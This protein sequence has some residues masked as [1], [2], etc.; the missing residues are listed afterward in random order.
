MPYISGDWFKTPP[1]PSQGF[2][3]EQK[4]VPAKKYPLS[5]KNGT[6]HVGPLYIREGYILRLKLAKK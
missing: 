6:A 1:P 2:I 4:K 3:G 5:R